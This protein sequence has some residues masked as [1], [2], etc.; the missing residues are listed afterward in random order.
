MD[1]LANAPRLAGAFLALAV[2]GC[3]G[4]TSAPPTNPPA[5]AAPSAAPTD[6]GPV[7]FAA[8]TE[9][10][11]FG[12]SSGLNNVKKLANWLAEHRFEARLFDVENDGQAVVR[13][14]TWLDANE[15]TACWSDFHATMRASLQGIA[16]GY[17][18]VRIAVAAGQTPA[19]DVVA[20]IATAA[21][22]AYA[23]AAPPNCP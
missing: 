6:A 19:E 18:T 11:G 2:A 21:A 3:S 23:M 7:A 14:V 1:R 16:D 22:A 4:A 17:A 9:R 8:W 5:S 20:E 12:G 15:P 10:Q 13:L